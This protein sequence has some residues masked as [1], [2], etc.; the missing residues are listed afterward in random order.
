MATGQ[1]PRTDRVKLSDAISISYYNAWP[2]LD[3][4]EKSY[5]DEPCTTKR[6]AGGDNRFGS[7]RVGDCGL[8][9]TNKVRLAQMPGVRVKI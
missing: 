6:N 1:L 5:S 4:S 3:R 7:A 8:A 9:Y 2:L